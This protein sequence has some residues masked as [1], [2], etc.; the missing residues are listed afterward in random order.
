MT[1]TDKRMKDFFEKAYLSARTPWPSTQPTAAEKV[2]RHHSGGCSVCH[3]VA[4]S[5]AAP[6][7]IS[8]GSA[9]GCP[10]NCSESG[11]PASE[12][13]HGKAI[14]GKPAKSD[15]TVKRDCQGSRSGGIGP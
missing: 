4:S 5:Y 10:T 6:A 7:C 8:S 9:S 15:G 13:P 2:G 12:R 1:I 14:V 11:R 3:S